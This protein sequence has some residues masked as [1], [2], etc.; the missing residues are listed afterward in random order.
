MPPLMI[1][2]GAFALGISLSQFSKSGSWV[3]AAFAAAFFLLVGGIWAYLQGKRCSFLWLPLCFLCLGYLWMES[4]Q[5]VFP[6]QLN[7]ML[8]H[9]VKVEG[10]VESLPSVYPN[11]VVFVLEQPTVA[12]NREKWQGKGKIQVVYYIP[13]NSTDEKAADTAALLPGAVVKVDGFL[14]LAPAALSPGEFDYRVYLERRGIIV[15][16]KADSSPQIMSQ[17]KGFSSFWAALRMRIEGNINL[18]LPQEQSFFLQGLLLSSK[19]GITP[20]DRDIYQKTGV[21]HLFAVS[22]L[23]LGFVFIALM[24]AASFLG[25]K[26]PSTFIM[27]TAGL[28]GYA[29]L[30]N[31]T[32]PITRAAVMATVGLAAYLWQQRQNAANSLALAAFVLLLFNPALLFD[33]GFQLSFTATWGIIY[34]AVP[35]NRH[36]PLPAGFKETLTVPIAAQLA[37]LPL[38][39]VYFNRVVVLGL[40]ANILVVPLAGLVVYLG[41]AGI[42]LALVAPGILNPFFLA[43]GALS[44]PIKGLLG[45]LAAL[46]GAASL[47]PSPPLW[48]CLLWF[49]TLIILGWAL[50][51]G[52]AVSFPHFRFRS[53]AHCWIVPSLLMLALC[54]SLLCTGFWA[55]RSGKLEITFLDVGQG[56]AVLVRTPAGRTML[57]DAGG[58]PSY[59]NSSFDPGREVVVPALARAGISKLD[60][61]VNSHPHE[62]HLGGIPAVLNNIK[63]GRFLAPPLEHPTPLVLQVQQ[64]LEQKKIPVSYI[65]TGTEIKLDPVVKI[66][67]LGP[68]ETLFSG[69]RSDANNNSLVLRIT[70]GKISFLLTGDIEQEGMS[71]LA[72]RVENGKIAGSIR[73]DVLKCPHHGSSYSISP[74]FSDAV[75][76][77]VV[78]ISVGHNN[79]GHPDP[80]TISFWRERGALVLRTDEE[81]AI[82]LITDGVK[83]FNLQSRSQ[84]S[85]QPVPVGSPGA[86]VM[87]F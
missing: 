66:S 59:L 46:P 20:E 21:M 51:E 74:E 22:G 41:L 62:D 82:T 44:L 33:P 27:V 15:Q 10:V 13:E 56:D 75:Q 11:R 32:P 76:P 24:A 87:A 9:Y 50:R 64:L 70:Y 60:L 18:S 81:G 25:L 16:I 43:A 48:L 57:V 30:I 63:V 3:L 28:W 67:V 73:A 68:P 55:N 38:T 19:E 53:V 31:F 12:L 52:F 40:L 77:K 35:L 47:V 8:G 14:D 83:L 58:S 4:S 26:G 86:Q 2:T 45:L 1:I 23:H 65:R 71:D 79:F 80:R 69:T 84:W 29:A 36:L 78:V 54:L 61:V 17:E 39:A 49:I 37:I 85:E 5:T 42:L 72:Y 34:L 6:Q 7:P